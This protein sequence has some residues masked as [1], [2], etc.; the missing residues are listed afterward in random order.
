[1]TWIPSLSLSCIFSLLIHHS[2]RPSSLPFLS[3]KDK[4]RSDLARES[5]SKKKKKKKKKKKIIIKFL[6]YQIKEFVTAL[7]HI[8]K[9]NSI[10]FF[11]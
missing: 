7:N 5:K 6:L 8:K 2:S 1:M 10:I 4:E 9:K 3:S 11:L